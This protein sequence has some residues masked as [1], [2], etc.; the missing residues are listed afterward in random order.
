M[1]ANISSSIIPLRQLWF[2]KEWLKYPGISLWM[3]P[4]NEKWRYI[5]GAFTKWSLNTN[6]QSCWVND[7]SYLKL[8]C[9]L[10][11][12]IFHLKSKDIAGWKY[13]T[14]P[15]SVDRIYSR[16]FQFMKPWQTDHCKS[17]SL[18]ALLS[19]AAPEVV[20][21]TTSPEVVITTT[22]GAASDNKVGIIILIFKCTIS[23]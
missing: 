9:F 17:V 23:L 19:Q 18:Q 3:R 13:H 15:A 10:N 4:A 8:Y 12:R 21:T 14:T 1:P 6:L 5:V 7:K 11:S 22:S 20:V 16:I 2:G